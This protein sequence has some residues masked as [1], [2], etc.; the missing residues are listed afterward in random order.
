MPPTGPS[1]EDTNSG[2][3]SVVVN[4][5]NYA[6]GNWH[7]LLAQYNSTANTIS[8]SVANQDGTGTNVTVALPPGY[9]PLP[10]K[11]EGNLF[12]GRYRYPLNDGA[13]TDPR[14]FIGSIDEVQVSSGLITPTTGQLGYVSVP[15]NITGISLSGSTV[16]IQFTGSPAAAASSYTL[17]GSPTVN[18]TFTT[19]AASV[20]SLG[21]GNF[22][23]T[24]AKSG[25]VE[26][27]KIKH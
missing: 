25:A 15:P 19:L 18:G 26:F 13:N 14:T 10:A 20:T 21:G 23:A 16:T 6:D 11:F 8:L 9:S 22:Q 24:V 12:V 7:Y 1:W 2:I 4:N 3:Q 27:Y 5:A 17:V